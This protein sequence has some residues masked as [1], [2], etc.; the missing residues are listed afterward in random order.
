MIHEKQRITKIIN[1]MTLFFFSMGATNISTNIRTEKEE[2]VITLESNFKGDQKKNIEKLVKC[3][4][5]PKQEGME[6][7]YWG[8]TGECNIDTELSVVGMM[9][10][11][12]DMEIKG[13]QIKLILYRK[14]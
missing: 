5:I 10:D 12:T 13:D 6:E 9:T 2:T 4:K 8:L 7:Y 1:E 11:R 14:N 3:M